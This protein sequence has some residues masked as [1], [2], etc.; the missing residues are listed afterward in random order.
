MTP[1]HPDVS[2][3]FEGIFDSSQYHPSSKIFCSSRSVLAYPHAINFRRLIRLV[4]RWMCLLVLHR[5]GIHIPLIE[6]PDVLQEP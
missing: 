6:T 3:R 1:E 2:A 5:Q 4:V